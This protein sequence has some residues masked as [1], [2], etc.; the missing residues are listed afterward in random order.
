MERYFS[1]FFVEVVDKKFNN[2]DVKSDKTAIIS[3]FDN[4]NEAVGQINFAFI[5]PEEIYQKIDNQ[6]DIYFPGCYIDGFSLRKYRN[7]RNIPETNKIILNHVNFEGAFF[8][9]SDKEEAVLD[10]VN[11]EWN[12]DTLN[13]KNCVF[14]GANEINFDFS[15]FRGEVLFE[16]S[17]FNFIDVSFANTTFECNLLSFKNA[18]F[19]DGLKRFE[20]IHFHCNEV[21]FIN[22][23]FGDGDVSF[24]NSEFYNASVLFK[25]A[26]FG[27]GR[28]DYNKVN[29]GNGNTSFEKAE[30]G[31]GNINFRSAYFGEGDVEFTRCIFGSGDVSFIAAIFE[32]GDV[33]FA[34]TEFGEGKLSFKQA[35]F[36]GGKL[37][38]HYAHFGDGD[39]IFE[40]TTFSQ[41]NVDFRAV[42]FGSGR[43]TFN[44]ANFGQGEVVF[45]ASELKNGRITFR[46]TM[47][48]SGIFNFEMADFSNAELVIDDVNFGQGKV[49]F[50]K[51]KFA[52]LSLES[53]QMN[54]YFD[55]RVESCGKLDLSNTIV[56]DII[57]IDSAEHKTSIKALDLNG[58]RLLGR[59]YIDWNKNNVKGLILD[60]DTSHANKA[61]QFRVLK[62]NYNLI[63]Q[64]E[65]EDQAYVEF[66][67]SESKS[68]VESCSELNLLKRLWSYIRYFFQLLVF[69]KVGLYATNPIRVLFS[70]TVIFTAFSLL[71]TGLQFVTHDSAIVSSLF[72]DGDP[73]DLTIVQKSFYHSAIT[74][75]TI[76]YGDYYPSGA[77]R[78]LSAV[79]GFFGL[80]LMS[81][82]TVAFVRKI[83]R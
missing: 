66:K 81:Y 83:L 79:E 42:D 67:R 33:S 76:G 29:F 52:L 30:F 64:Y 53:S 70:M 63:G 56:K 32:K 24:S 18:L 60:Q 25:V 47:F 75:L 14:A 41:G 45:E 9:F 65:Y 40:R 15:T 74:F 22:T 35:Y 44:K 80:F 54:N 1:R 23:E 72:S 36:G 6:E 11:S 61:A 3:L 19:R 57:D 58:I 16:Y 77:I 17:L 38:F 12:G 37:D 8:D 50:R 10:F 48:G 5:T 51:S 46:K 71:Y 21:S 4:R 73:R 39:I 31:E 49:S 43:I 78:W 62:E 13:F 68:I 69:D 26:R 82:F 7:E 55:L 34:G 20:N 2:N 27:K 28:I 59:I